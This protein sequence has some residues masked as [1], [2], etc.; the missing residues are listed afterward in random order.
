MTQDQLSDSVQ[1]INLP[2]GEMQNSCI[3]INKFPSTLV[4]CNVTVTGFSYHVKHLFYARK[5]LLATLHIGSQIQRFRD[6]LLRTQFDINTIYE[7][8]KSLMTYKSAPALK[9]PMDL[10]EIHIQIKDRL[11]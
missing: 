6:G 5:Y 7:S 3:M 9:V 1:M 8:L 2:C 11:D 4:S 10:R